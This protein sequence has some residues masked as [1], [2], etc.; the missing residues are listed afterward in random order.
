[1][2]IDYYCKSHQIWPRAPNA[3]GTA[4]ACVE[5]YNGDP[6]QSG[7]KFSDSVIM[8]TTKSSLQGIIDFA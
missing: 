5:F 3:R 1:M 2:I 6:N 4:S 8:M 7:L